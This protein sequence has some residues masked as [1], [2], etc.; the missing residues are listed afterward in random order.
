MPNKLQEWRAF[1][2][3]RA[4]RA[5]RRDSVVQEWDSLLD[6]LF[7]L[8][9]WI[10]FMWFTLCLNISE[11]TKTIHKCP[12]IRADSRGKSGK[13]WWGFFWVFHNLFTPRLWLKST[14]L[15]R[16]I[17]VSRTGSEKMVAWSSAFEC[18]WLA[19]ISRARYVS[20]TLFSRRTW[21]IQTS[22][23]HHLWMLVIA[24]LIARAFHPGLA[25]VTGHWH[26]NILRIMNWKKPE[27]LIEIYDCVFCMRAFIPI[28]FH[29]FSLPDSSLIDGEGCK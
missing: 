7:S 18:E 21:S 3:S 12:R 11:Y 23:V 20:G 17:Y 14:E 15:F 4:K 13:F 22:A 2:V 24:W 25:W 29:V 9:H 28:V 8:D 27:S 26:L 19:T 1:S 10:L 5:E 16:P 6:S